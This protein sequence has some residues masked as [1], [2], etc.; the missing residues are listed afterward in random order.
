MGQRK[1]DS[2]ALVEGQVVD[3]DNK[4]LSVS[5][6]RVWSKSTRVGRPAISISGRSN[7]FVD[8]CHYGPLDQLERNGLRKRELQRALAVDVIRQLCPQVLVASRNGVDRYV[9]APTRVVHDVLPVQ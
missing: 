6:E 5:I 7:A 3:E 9:V 2:H 4:T 8:E 1:F